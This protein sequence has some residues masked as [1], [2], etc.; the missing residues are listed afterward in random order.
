MPDP[1]QLPYLLKLLDD[2]SKVVKKA[3]LKELN[4]FGPS[5][6]E[7]LARL[8]EPL[9]AE[10]RRTLQNILQERSRDL[11]KK[12]WPKWR[13]LDDDKEKLEAALGLVAE[14]QTGFVYPV[15]L[16]AL[17]NGLTEGVSQ[18]FVYEE[19]NDDDPLLSGSNCSVS[20]GCC[21]I[22]NGCYAHRLGRQVRPPTTPR[23]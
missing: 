22:G 15:K 3:V 13:D 8:P 7:E 6:E 2:D 20:T 23:R 1:K 9:T 5:L 19:V 12:N 21:N 10:Q 18:L 11:L 16:K 17:L 4:G 14:F